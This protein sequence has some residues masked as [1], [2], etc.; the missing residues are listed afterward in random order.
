MDVGDH[1]DRR[2]ADDRRQRGGVLVLRHGARA[3]SRSPPTRAPRSAPS[4]PRRRASSS[5]SST[6]R[7]RARRRRSR[8]CR[9]WICTLARHRPA[10]VAAL[11]RPAASAP[12]RA[13][14]CRSRGRRRRAAARPRCRPPRRARRPRAGPTRPRTP[15]TSANRMW[16]PSSGSSGS[17]LSS[18]SESEISAE[19]PE[20]VL[21]ALLDRSEEPCDDPDRARDLARG[22]P[23]TSRPSECTI[24]FVTSPV[25]SK[26]LSPRRR[27][28]RP[29]PREH[30]AEPIPAVDRAAG[31]DAGRAAPPCRRAATVS[32]SGRPLRA[33]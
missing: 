20:V 3:R 11:A 31:V 28:R 9:R 29:S 8:R 12:T 5:A 15:S 30:E 4:S 33:R 10:S 24:S 21:D 23:V 18:A 7:R 32:T 13:G 22:P 26:R 16:P 1:R 27:R 14:R 2:E 6:A 25:T 19:H 17:R